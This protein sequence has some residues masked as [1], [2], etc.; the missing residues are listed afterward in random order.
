MTYGLGGKERLHDL[1]Q[2]AWRDATPGIADFDNHR[3]GFVRALRRIKPGAD[4]QRAPLWGRISRVDHQVENGVLQ[5]IGIGTD[6]RIFVAQVEYEV[7]M[8][9]H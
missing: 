7:Q 6:P 5:L 2:Y 4:S 8:F 1:V 3:A 9:R